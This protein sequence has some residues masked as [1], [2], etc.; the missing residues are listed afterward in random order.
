MAEAQSSAASAPPKEALRQGVGKGLV[1]TIAVVVAAAGILTGV[2]LGRTVFAPP[3]K[4]QN[5][6]VGTNIPFPP[7]E[8]YDALNKTYYGFDIDFA[9]QIAN[10]TH[11]TL[12]IEN[13][14]DFS[15]L[16]TTVGANGVDMAASAITE[17]G[18]QGAARNMSMSFSIPYYDAN[19]AVLVKSSSSLSCPSSGCTVALLK[20]LTLGVQTGTTSQGWVQQYFEPNDT[21]GWSQIQNFTAVDTEVTAVTAGSIDAVIIDAGPATAIAA[22]SGGNLKVAG[23]IITNELYG[24][25]VALGDPQGLLPVINNLITTDMTNG[26]YAAEVHKWFG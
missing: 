22:A 16:L 13:F 26:W 18:S 6:V 3:G 21:S 9:S 24:F 10:A 19:Q 7:F 11:R 4:P 25:A 5:L 23:L 8:S 20:N 17:S 2:E 12:F 14:A 1:I 15:A